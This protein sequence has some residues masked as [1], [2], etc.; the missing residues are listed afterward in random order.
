MASMP[1]TRVSSDAGENVHWS[2]DSKRLHWSLGATLSSLRLDDAFDVLGGTAGEK[3]IE[4]RQT[5]I[6]FEV[7]YGAPRG[8]LALIGGR[9]ITLRN[10]EQ[11]ILD[12]GVVVISGNRITAVGREGEIAVPPSAQQIDVRGKTVIPGLIDVHWHG[13]QGSDQVIPQQ[14]WVNYASL[15]YGVTTLHDPSNDTHEIFAAAELQRAGLIVAPRIFSTGTILYGAKDAENAQIESLEDARQHLR[16]LQA[17]GAFSVKSYNQPRRNQRQQVI[18]AARELGMMVVPEGGALLAQNLTQVVDG[19]TGVEHTVPVGA[20]YD[21][22]TQLWAGTEVGYTPTLGVAYGGLSGE[23]YWYATTDVWAEEPLSHFV[24][25]QILDA[26]SRRREIAPEE[27]YNHIRQAEVAKRLLDAGVPVQLGAHGQREGLA[28]HWEMWMFVQG[29]MS[30]FEA[31]RAATLDGAKYLGLDR[32]LGSIEAG[33]LADL[34]ILDANPL[35]DI[36]L[37]TK[38]HQVLANGRLYDAATM[39]ELAPEPRP[40][41]AFWWE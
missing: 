35:E 25:R 34:V 18:A 21:D 23:R 3:K 4:P 38:I 16:R 24:P 39:N 6:G 27:E 31:L 22:V 28:A 20:I 1:V 26:R 29:G 19:H 40:R 41:Q 15:A 9:V 5:S 14:N 37:S 12:P 11:E 8:E 13:A 36:R 7:P 2:G 32:D 30:P 33:K 17:A 10:G